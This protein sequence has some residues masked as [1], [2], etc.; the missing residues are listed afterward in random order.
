MV[1]RLVHHRPSSDRG[2]TKRHLPHVHQ[3]RGGLE[4]VR[5]QSK[6]PRPIYHQE[7]SESSGLSVVQGKNCVMSAVMSKQA[8]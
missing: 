8:F 4:A 5:V 3:A 2:Q 1:H 7:I 6:E